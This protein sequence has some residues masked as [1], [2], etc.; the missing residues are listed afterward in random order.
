MENPERGRADC[1]WPLS[2]FQSVFVG[3][4]LEVWSQ[5]C[6]RNTTV[7]G[8]ETPA[9]VWWFTK[10]THRTQHIVTLMAEIYHSKMM[11]GKMSTGKWGMRR[12]LEKTRYKIPSGL[13]Q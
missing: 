4:F 10:R 11:Q 2:F 8:T 3:Y 9:Q 1:I 6:L 7:S 12:S 5:L 13:F